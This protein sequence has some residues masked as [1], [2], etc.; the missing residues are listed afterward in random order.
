MWNSQMRKP[1]SM[2]LTC[3]KIVTHL[4]RFTTTLDICSPLLKKFSKKKIKWL[5]CLTFIGWPQ[6]QV[7]HTVHILLLSM[8]LR[9]QYHIYRIF[10]KYGPGVNYFQMASDQALNWTRRSFEIQKNSVI[11]C[12]QCAWYQALIWTRRLFEPGRYFGNLRYA[13]VIFQLVMCDTDYIF[14]PV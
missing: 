12:K 6:C 7:S 14:C 2:S 11:N 5:F 8:A 10:P 13:L 1:H 9:R 4:L 3:V